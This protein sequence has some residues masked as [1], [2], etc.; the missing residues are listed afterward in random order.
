MVRGGCS[1]P[2]CDDCRTEWPDRGGPVIWFHERV[3]RHT[4][5][6]KDFPPVWAHGGQIP[7]RTLVNCKCGKTWVRRERVP[8]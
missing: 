6:R 7:K 4:V 1:D 8:R 5:K 3:L 2:D